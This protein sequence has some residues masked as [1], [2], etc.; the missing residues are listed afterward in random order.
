MTTPTEDARAALAEYDASE[1]QHDAVLVVPEIV[2][3]LRALIEPPTADERE[4]LK[5]ALTEG[6]WKRTGY[7]VTWENIGPLMD[8]IL[9]AGF[10]RGDTENC[11]DHD[12]RCC[13]THHTHVSPHRGCILR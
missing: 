6:Y 13:A 11:I 4:A 5:V 9:A 12:N 3:A 7:R 8:A 2:A 10:R 1:T